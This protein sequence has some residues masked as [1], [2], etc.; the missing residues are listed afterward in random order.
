MAYPDF[1]SAILAKQGN[2]LQVARNLSKRAVAS[3]PTV[4]RGQGSFLRWWGGLGDEPARL[5]EWV[6]AIF[7]TTVTTRPSCPWNPTSYV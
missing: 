7:L 4:F 2:R 3:P 6:V 5:G 1:N